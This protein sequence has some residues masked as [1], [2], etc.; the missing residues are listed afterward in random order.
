MESNNHSLTKSITQYHLNDTCILGLRITLLVFHMINTLLHGI[1]T[2]ILVKI[3]RQRD[4]RPQHVFLL[5]LS[6]SELTMNVLE[7]TRMITKILPNAVTTFGKYIKMINF[8]GTWL[9][10]YLMMVYITIDRLLLISMKVRYNKV[11]SR[12]RAISVFSV[13]WVA[14]GIFAFSTV[15][16]HVFLDFDWKDAYFKYF[17]SV[18]D[19]LFIILAVIT[20]QYIL[21]KL[22]RSDKR[23]AVVD[24]EVASKDQDHLQLDKRGRTPRANTSRLWKFYGT[25]IFLVL[26]FIVFLIIPDLTYLFYGILAQ[27]KSDALF[28]ACSLSYAFANFTDVIIYLYMQPRVRKEVRKIY[29][30]ND[31]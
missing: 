31:V 5:G 18:A 25:T 14:G 22:K 1:G 8:S 29:R 4:A 12:Q 24:R 28:Y 15:M 21:W 6:T 19:T 3:V 7:A 16:S 23:L 13:T 11:L 10:V 26:T 27:K 20:Y 9:V 17:F 30:K 2:Y